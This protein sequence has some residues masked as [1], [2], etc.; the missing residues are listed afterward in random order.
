MV[1]LN[2][3]YILTKTSCMWNFKFWVTSLLLY[4]PFSNACQITYMCRFHIAF[5]VGNFRLSVHLWQKKMLLFG[6]TSMTLEIVLS[7][8]WSLIVCV[9]MN[10]DSFNFYSKVRRT[11]TSQFPTHHPLQ[12][13]LF[14]LWF[15]CSMNSHRH[16]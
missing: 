15:L 16:K 6:S 13:C 2:N 9:W 8:W 14:H 12:Y 11:S 4:F 1:C 7:T 3:C 10:T 5:S